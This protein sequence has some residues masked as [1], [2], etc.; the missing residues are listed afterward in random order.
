MKLG[1][2]TDSVSVEEIPKQGYI[3]A[4]EGLKPLGANVR[5]SRQE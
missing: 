5:G 2:E 3:V 1:F 4:K